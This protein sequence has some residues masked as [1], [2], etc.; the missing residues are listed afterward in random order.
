MQTA[1][2][3]GASFFLLYTLQ[4]VIEH[5]R[6]VASVGNFPGYRKL[7]NPWGKIAALIQILLGR[8]RSPV[9]VGYDE[10]QKNGWDAITEVS[11]LP[12]SSVFFL[13]ADPAA[14]K[15]VT[16]Y[17]ARFPKPVED[18]ALLRFW[19]DNIVASEGEEWKRIR[20]IVAPAFS[21]RNN[22][23]VWDETVRIVLD[24]IDTVW[25]RAPEVTT[26]HAIEFTLPIALFVISVA[27]FGRRI[28]WS[29]NSIIPLGYEMSFKEALNI[30]SKDV[31]IKA[32]V[33]SWAMGLSKRWSRVRTAFD[34]IE[35]YMFEMVR[36]G[37]N[38]EKKEEQADLF[39]WL[40]D[41]A[42]EE[43]K[44]TNREL[45]AN[46]FIFLLAGHETTAH[47]LF[48]FGLLALYP[49]EQ[50]RLYQQIRGIISTPGRIP[51]YEEMPRFTYSM[52][53]F[54]ET[55]RLL[56]AC[57]TSIPKKAAEDTSLVIGNVEGKQR[58]LPVPK[59]TKINIFAPAVHKNPRF[60]DDPHA[61]KPERFLGDWPKDAFIPFSQGPRACIGR[62]FFETE[63]IAILTIL[64]S[65]YKITIKDE[66][67]FADETFDE[68]K[69]RVLR[70]TPG[71]STTPV[72]VPLTFTRRE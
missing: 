15:E 26:D 28:S 64:V 53:V 45:L 37:Q 59:G 72:R 19:G 16:T 66:H 13:L 60:W 48:C 67:Q 58:I 65:Q 31:G 70:S 46:I 56:Y 69:A 68:R 62:R 1:F 10:F 20:K 38:A 51:I 49:D 18:Y 36:L 17:R 63:G 29:D 8:G 35:K 33:P 39:T 40:L 6:A 4:K 61:F 14:I 21:E 25:K 12:G 52:A 9:D 54:Y 7:F 34:E 3:L 50:E 24:L 2:I 23:L 30:I 42:E 57:V 55:L 11:F 5:R 27:G 44:L 32:F 43:D 71:L 47:T 22:K 41:A